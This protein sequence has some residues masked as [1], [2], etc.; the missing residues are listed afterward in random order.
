MGR[1]E[2]TG[3]RGLAKGPWKSCPSLEIGRWPSINLQGGVGHLGPL[4]Q[5]Q[6]WGGG[7]GE[8][9]G[10]LQKWSLAL[11]WNHK[12]QRQLNHYFSITSARE[13]GNTFAF[14]HA[15]TQYNL[16]KKL[17]PDPKPSSHF[18]PEHITGTPNEA[19]ERFFR[20]S[21]STRGCKMYS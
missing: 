5:S 18:D 13:G 15:H 10:L 12:I 2:E 21:G 14:C 11:S 9:E 3:R 7:Q 20:T 4:I 19:F 16:R 1:R 6:L 17:L 8:R